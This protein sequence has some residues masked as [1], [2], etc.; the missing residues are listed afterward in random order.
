[1]DIFLPL[2]CVCMFG[3]FI[4]FKKRNHSSQCLEAA[5]LLFSGFIV[6]GYSLRCVTCFTG[7]EAR[8]SY[9]SCVH[10]CPTWSFLW[11]MFLV[12]LSEVVGCGERVG[13]ILCSL[14]CRDALDLGFWPS[15]WGHEGFAAPVSVPLRHSRESLRSGLS[16]GYH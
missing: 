6:P 5:P 14:F 15:P 2:L 9:Q 7:W 12:P 10:G 8:A 11:R 16:R 1:M 4:F 13:A 3:D